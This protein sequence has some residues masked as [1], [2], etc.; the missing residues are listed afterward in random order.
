MRLTFLCTLTLTIA[1]V[2]TSSAQTSMEPLLPVVQLE[3][4]RAQHNPRNLLDASPQSRSA[5]ERA[6]PDTQ[7]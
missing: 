2:C 3:P 7:K 6:Q 5:L 4:E 1:Y